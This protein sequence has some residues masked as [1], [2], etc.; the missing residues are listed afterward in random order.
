MPAPVNAGRLARA[1]L[2]TAESAGAVG[3]LVEV[4]TRL[5]AA[6]TEPER[7]YHDLHHLAEVLDRIDELATGATD[8]TVVRMAAW[9]HD[10][11]YGRGHDDEDQSAKLAEA[12][13]AGLG[14]GTAFIAE[15]AELVR[16][17]ATHDP[18]PGDANGAVLCDADLAILAAPPERYAAYAADVR[19]EW[20]HV[21]DAA[22]A[23]GRAA[24]LHALLARPQ[25]FR[26]TIGSAWE[27]TARA[28]M[29]AELML[30]GKPTGTAIAARD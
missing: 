4:G 25:L 6:Y 14:L 13:L 24:V 22:F 1:W 16:L 27:T 23:V 29:N 12:E 28:N 17:T 18:L 3:N 2:T 20:A 9:Y 11:V 5:L 30:L 26:T 21:G 7:A 8:V 10:A 19:L 15:V